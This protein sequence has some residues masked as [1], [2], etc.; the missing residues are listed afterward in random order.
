MKSE[1]V[2]RANNPLALQSSAIKRETLMRTAPLNQKYP[3]I[4]LQ[5]QNILTPDPERGTKTIV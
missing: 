1:P 2:P 4:A 3:T 5:Q